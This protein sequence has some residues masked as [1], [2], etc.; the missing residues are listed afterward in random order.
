MVAVSDRQRDATWPRKPD[1]S[2]RGP[3]ARRQFLRAIAGIA[4]GSVL[5]AL[6]GCS[7]I[8]LRGGA[9][10]VALTAELPA[11]APAPL[12]D[13]LTANVAALSDSGGPRLAVAWTSPDDLHRRYPPLVAAR[14]PPDLAVVGTLG[15]AALYWG[16]TL[17]DLTDVTNTALRVHGEVTWTSR[18]AVTYEKKLWGVPFYS[19][20]WAW[21][22]R[23][24]VLQA[25][26]I[27]EPSSYT[28]ALKIVDQLSG[29]PRAAAPW[30]LPLGADIVGE[31][32]VNQAIAAFGG[33]LADGS[34][35]RAALDTP[36]AVNALDTIA[37]MVSI[38]AAPTG[39]SL[40]ADAA[41]SQFEAGLL[42][43]MPASASYFVRLAR[44]A[45]PAPWAAKSLR[46]AYPLLGA[47][48]RYT[49]ADARY[50][51][52]S[53]ACRDVEQASRAIAVLLAPTLLR[54]ALRKCE[55]SVI[56]AYS[57]Y[58][59]DP[60]WD[61]DPVRPIFAACV[62]GDSLN[63]VELV[64]FGH[65][66]PASVQAAT[67][68]DRGLL[69]EAVRRIVEDRVPAS[70]AVKECQQRAEQAFQDGARAYAAAARRAAPAKSRIF[71]VVEW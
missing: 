67:A 46:V 62:R 9:A 54:Q 40:S 23:D 22:V 17:A 52:V 35:L 10:P 29:T 5:G 45:S 53:N 27:G 36:E 42:A 55:G 14:Q 31:A 57:D 63:R 12:R 58:L 61:A 25:L 50:F 44:G 8:A 47:K 34:G 60:W 20:G 16:A 24:D 70:Q 59:H 3:F 18:R 30:V 32:F 33:Q 2:G 7:A 41:A 39:L 4:T 1:F 11:D 66:G 71:G 43:I 51:V 69:R 49:S 28:D 68:A 13:L 15:P 65:N 56:P 37:R 48:L 38:S 21:L 64:D 6:P 19:R 26:R